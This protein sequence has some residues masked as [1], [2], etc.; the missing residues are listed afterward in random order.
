MKLRWMLAAQWERWPQQD[1]ANAAH[2]R[3]ARDG[4]AMKLDT[5]PQ[6]VAMSRA[7]TLLQAMAGLGILLCSRARM[8]PDLWGVRA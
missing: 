2:R 1:L 5:G 3:S 6:G 7:K 8:A 4:I